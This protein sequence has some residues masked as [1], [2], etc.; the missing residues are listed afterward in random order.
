MPSPARSEMPAVT[1]GEWI[2]VP[3]GFGDP[4]RLDRYPP[5]TYRWQSL[6]PMPAGRHHLMATA[7]GGKLY[8]FGGALASSWEPTATVWRY[9]PAD[10]AWQNLPAMPEARLAGAA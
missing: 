2:Y 9:D 4:A 1:L 7:Y 10:D 3:G 8:L 5:Q 6:V